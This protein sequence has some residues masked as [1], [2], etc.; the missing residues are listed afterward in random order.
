MCT[1]RL[2]IIIFH[3]T[4]LLFSYA[5]A[6]TYVTPVSDRLI[7]QTQFPSIGNPKHQQV[8]FAANHDLSSPSRRSE[9]EGLDRENEEP[10]TFTSELWDELQGGMVW[11]LNLIVFGIHQGPTN[12]LINPNNALDIPRHELGFR[13]RPDFKLF[14]RRLELGVNPR[15]SFLWDHWLEGNR[16]GRNE[17]DQEVFVNE[18]IAR[19]R[20]M[21]EL[22][23]SHGRNNLQWGPS[24]LI[25]SSNPFNVNN[26]RNN[27]KFQVGGLDYA[28]LVWIPSDEW[29]FSFIANI[30]EGRTTTLIPNLNQT[31]QGPSG[32]FEKVY[33]L[34]IDFTGTGKY[35]SL[36]PS[37]DENGF[38]EIGFLGGWT[39]S[40]AFFIYG[41]GRLKDGLNKTQLLGGA[42]YT[43]EAGPTVVIEY[44]RNE[45]GCTREPFALC[46]FPG[47]EKIDSKDVLFRRNYF[48]L[49]Y[50][51]THLY[52]DFNVFFRYFG[53]PDDN[54][55]RLITNLEYEAMDSAVLFLIPTVNIGGGRNG[56]SKSDR[57]SSYVWCGIDLLGPP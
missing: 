56:T 32:G 49:Q 54:S 9:N 17:L 1:F 46:F 34:K 41:E 7:A 30:A 3:C 12:S 43:F 52:D 55:H 4:F 8:F 21:D 11:R 25:S 22:F 36:I 50:S 27:P 24:Y 37:I 39:L 31:V 57:I 18:W 45:N 14:F 35:A 26:G 51:D 19:V 38:G 6:G 48:L 15:W 47:L 20:L 23:V 16:A 33:A 42:S 44:F 28:Q 13:F 10:F 29:T 53:T 2:S 5:W 40:D